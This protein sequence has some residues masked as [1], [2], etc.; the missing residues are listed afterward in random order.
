MT[1]EALPSL[2]CLLPN[3]VRPGPI[4]TPLPT[5]WLEGAGR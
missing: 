4:L 2:T 3:I 5:E 1:G